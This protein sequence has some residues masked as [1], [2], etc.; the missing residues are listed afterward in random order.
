[1]WE[2]TGNIIKAKKSAIIYWAEREIFLQ[3]AIIQPKW[4][5]ES[6]WVK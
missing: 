3:S 6:S 4:V 2:K 1:M 5:N